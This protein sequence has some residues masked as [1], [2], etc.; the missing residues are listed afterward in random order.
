MSSNIFDKLTVETFRSS[1]L[2][3]LREC[4]E[5]IPE[6][7]ESTWFVQGKEGIFDALNSLSAEEAYGGGRNRCGTCQSHPI[8]AEK[9]KFCFRWTTTGRNL[10]VKLGHRIHK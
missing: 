2:L 4:F 10:G 7:A 8:R 5:G 3:L 9:R 1:L 6:G